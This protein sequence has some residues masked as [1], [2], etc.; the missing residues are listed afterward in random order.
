MILEQH[1][2]SNA[3]HGYMGGENRLTYVSSMATTLKQLTT[4]QLVAYAAS[5][6]KYYFNRT[7][8]I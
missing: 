6:R 3:A 1:L 2:T 7:R 4:K 8:L 5:P